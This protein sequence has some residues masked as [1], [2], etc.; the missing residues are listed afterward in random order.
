M[1]VE[2]RPYRV[3][4]LCRC[5]AQG[6]SRCSTD[7]TVKS[8]YPSHADQLEYLAGDPRWFDSGGRIIITT[9]YEHLLRARNIRDIYKVKRLNEDEAV[10]LFQ[11]FAHG[12]RE[13][14]GQI[15][16][17]GCQLLQ[18][19]S[20]ALRVLGSFFVAKEV[21]VCKAALNKLRKI[22]DGEIL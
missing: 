5:W 13:E 14:V 10:M 16:E 15:Y 7:I 1:L 18:G 19:T 17:R 6:M 12:E 22:R 3:S 9:I 20:L 4:S 21:K 11:I 8:R 2:W